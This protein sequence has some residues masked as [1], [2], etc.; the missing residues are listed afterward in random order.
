[1]R[2]KS[3]AAI[4]LASSL[5]WISAACKTGP[6]TTPVNYSQYQLAY[7]L[8]TKYPDYFW[9]DPD[10]YPIA[11]EGQEQ[12]NA[13][14]QFATI[15][16]KASEFSAILTHLGLPDQS[17]YT[18]QEKLAIYREH[19]K[20]TDAIQMAPSGDGYSF[21]LRTGQTQGKLI[22]GTISTAGNIKVTSQKTSFNTCPICLTKGTLI[23]T[24]TGAVPVEQLRVGMLVWTLDAGGKRVATQVLTTASSRVPSGFL[25]VRITLSDGRTVTASPGHPTAWGQA[26]VDLKAGDTLDG[27]VIIKVK[28]VPYQGTTYDILPAGDSGVYWA[29]G[30]LLKS[31]LA[32]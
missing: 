10:I 24:P 7:Q 14:D 31:T 18:D 28:R 19:K 30:V 22:E 4:I 5:L 2:W 3:L 13:L 11:R 9:C 1:M 25:A 21:S 17:D 16:A 32:P 26:L 6:T 12:Q 20:L 29:N 27:A 23:D 8:F 15:R